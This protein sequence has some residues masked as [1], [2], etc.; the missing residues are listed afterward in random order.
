MSGFEDVRIYS[1]D[2]NPKILRSSNP[3]IQERYI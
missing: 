2:S 1:M 3:Q